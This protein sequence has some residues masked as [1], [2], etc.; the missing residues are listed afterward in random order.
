[1]HGNNILAVIQGWPL[2]WEVVLYTNC[3]FGTWVPGRYIQ[4][5]PYSGWP[6][7]GF[8]CS[9]NWDLCMHVVRLLSKTRI[10]MPWMCWLSLPFITSGPIKVSY[11]GSVVS[12]LHILWRY[13]H[14][15]RQRIYEWSISSLQCSHFWYNARREHACLIKNILSMESL[16]CLCFLHA[17]I[18]LLAHCM[19]VYI[20][21][22][23]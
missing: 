4:R 12:I 3:S 10:P 16:N 14:A 2:Y 19:T 23:H 7:R 5:W 18:Q 21:R 8:H 11:L 22:I 6:L 15:W 17:V 1:M 13:T 9:A 20:I